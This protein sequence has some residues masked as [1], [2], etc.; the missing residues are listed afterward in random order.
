MS[1][2]EPIYDEVVAELTRMGAR[3]LTPAQVEAIA[4]RA[5]DE[6][7]SAPIEGLG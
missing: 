5:F 1:V 4:D 3:V 2:D 6:D 7:G